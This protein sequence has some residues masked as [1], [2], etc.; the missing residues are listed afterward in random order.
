MKDEIET[1]KIGQTTMFAKT[2]PVNILFED[3]YDTPEGCPHIG[4]RFELLEIDGIYLI[5][6]QAIFSEKPSIH[7]YKAFSTK[8]DAKEY[9]SLLG[10]AIDQEKTLSELDVDVDD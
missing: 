5:V 1:I 6:M 8:E 2:V 10:V 7:S 4:E 3:I 9:L